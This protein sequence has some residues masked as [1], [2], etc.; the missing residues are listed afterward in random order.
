MNMIFFFL[1]L[2]LFIMIFFIFLKHPLIMGLMLI[3]NTIFLCVFVSLFSFSSWNSYILF[4]MFLGG[5]L[6]LFLY[7]ISLISTEIFSML[8]IKYF[9]LF[10]YFFIMFYIIFNFKESFFND[11]FIFFCQK[12]FSGLTFFFLEYNSSSILFLI[13]YIFLSLICIINLIYLMKDKGTMTSM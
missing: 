8:N 5:I 12:D 7:N 9:F 10:F 3:L 13:S 6:I 1:C 2:F 11:T 4:L